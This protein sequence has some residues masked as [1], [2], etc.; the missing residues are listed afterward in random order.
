MSQQ[1][2]PPEAESLRKTIKELI[3]ETATFPNRPADN[4][5]A[6]FHKNK[7]GNKAYRGDLL[8]EKISLL[9]EDLRLKKQ[10][11]IGAVCLLIIIYCGP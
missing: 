6:I 7:N 2:L 3:P 11:R 8:A 10:L 1:L 9:T 4:E 5:A